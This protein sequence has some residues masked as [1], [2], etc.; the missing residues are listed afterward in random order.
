MPKSAPNP[1]AIRR[2]DGDHN[3]DRHRHDYDYNDISSIQVDFFSFSDCLSCDRVD[4]SIKSYE[5][6]ASG[7]R[8]GMDRP[9]RPSRPG[10]RGWRWRWLRPRHRVRPELPGAGGWRI[11]AQGESCGKH[12]RRR[13]F[14]E[15]Y[16]N[17]KYDDIWGKRLTMELRLPS[18]PPM[19]K[20]LIMRKHMIKDEHA[21]FRLFDT[22]DP[23]TRTRLLT[24][25]RVNPRKQV[26]LH[27]LSYLSILLED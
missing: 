23:A 12:S 21:V 25:H 15:K 7:H 17:L 1:V 6:H 5:L 27:S 26:I 24:R 13:G 19:W 8:S 2:S 14:G 4:H 22:N 3:H 9:S 20:F 11:G 16:K 18:F 10:A